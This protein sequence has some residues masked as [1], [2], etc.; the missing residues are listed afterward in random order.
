MFR[1]GQTLWAETGILG[2][3]DATPSSKFAKLFK[4]KWRNTPVVKWRMRRGCNFWSEKM[5]TAIGKWKEVVR[6]SIKCGSSAP[7]NGKQ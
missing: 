1:Y 6:S 3:L 5:P 2:V 4:M 7:M